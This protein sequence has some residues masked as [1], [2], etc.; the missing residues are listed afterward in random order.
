MD[1]RTAHSRLDF[2]E[3][4]HVAAVGTRGGRR[5]ASGVTSRPAFMVS[6]AADAAV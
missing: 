5:W 2:E 3:E 1:Q 6:K 4:M